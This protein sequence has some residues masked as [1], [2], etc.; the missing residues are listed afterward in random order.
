MRIPP[1]VAIYV[2][3]KNPRRLLRDFH[4]VSVLP[5]DFSMTVRTVHSPGSVDVGPGWSIVWST[6]PGE[7]DRLSKVYDPKFYAVHRDAESALR[8]RVASDA[9][10]RLA[11]EYVRNRLLAGSSSRQ[12]MTMSSEQ[13][14]Q[15]GDIVMMGKHGE[16]RVRCKV[17]KVDRQW[18]EMKTLEKTTRFDPLHEGLIDYPEGAVFRAPHDH[19]TV[20]R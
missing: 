15:K 5:I 8:S 12:E 10:D 3:P 6:D 11:A 7:M 19:I 2:T 4:R 13:P 18:V 14:I 16:D 1:D 17:E 9:V 20:I